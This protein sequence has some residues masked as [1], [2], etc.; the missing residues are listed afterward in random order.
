MLAVY[1]YAV[2]VKYLWHVVC[3]R[4]EAKHCFCDYRNRH[5]DDS[6]QCSV[7]RAVV[8]VARSADPGEE[9][10]PRWMVGRRVTGAHI[11]PSLY[12]DK[13]LQTSNR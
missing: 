10:T 12:C 4:N 2:A 7:R 6:V 13:C 11:E 5:C 3:S 1:N 8:S 9:K